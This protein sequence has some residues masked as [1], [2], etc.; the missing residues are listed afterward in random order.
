MK[1]KITLLLGC[2]LLLGINTSN[3]QIFKKIKDR[4]K[5]AAEETVTRKTEEKTAEAI[6]SLIEKPFKKKKEKKRKKSGQESNEESYE[7]YP[8][9][10]YE[11]NPSEGSQPKVW[12]QYNF[13][14]GDKI[15]FNDDLAEE[16][17]GEFPS[18]WDILKGNAENASFNGENIIAMKH[19]SIIMPLMDTHDYLPEVFTLEFDIY[20]D[21]K[22]FSY[23]SNYYLRLGPESGSHYFGEGNKDWITAI[24]IKKNSIKFTADVNGIRKNFA[25]S[26]S[27][28]EELGKGKWRHIA[29]AFNK[30][31]F[32]MFIDE[33]RVVNIPN[34]GF[35]PE[36]FSIGYS[37]NYAGDDEI[38]AV[39]NIRLAEGGKK[40]YDQVVEE[41]KYVTRGI[42][43]DV[44]SATIKPESG[45][46]LKEVASMMQEHDDLNF[47]IE[48]HTDSDGDD[49]YNL[50]LSGERAEAVKWALV[51][52]GIAED[53][54]ETEGKGEAVPVADNTSPEGKANN[55]RVE[56]IK[57]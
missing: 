9:D 24:A 30:R 50:S 29:I 11:E 19:S 44:N 54:F 26:K 52:Q 14:P 25:D 40:L 43:F 31:S 4:A 15:I 42:L 35:K 34:L 2:I 55:R 6:D 22:K 23:R 37:N 41:G 48:G 38:I 21:V 57:L 56:F 47:R 39:K 51:E 7:E 27:E 49:E 36:M 33:Y 17:N 16:E 13:V 20:F 1:I 53:R 32:K 8:E 5:Q 18:R 3:A 28:L 46:V 12:S 45:G 10:T